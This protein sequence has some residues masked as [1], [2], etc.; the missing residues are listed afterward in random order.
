VCL[1]TPSTKRGQRA[2]ARH[3]LPAV[4]HE[5]AVEVMDLMKEMLKDGVYK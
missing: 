1:G 3:T 2:G 5:D 4:T